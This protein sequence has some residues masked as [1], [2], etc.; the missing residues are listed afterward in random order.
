[1]KDFDVIGTSV[2]VDRVARVVTSESK[3]YH[4]HDDNTC[5]TE[6]PPIMEFPGNR[7]DNITENVFGRLTVIGYA[8][9][10][11]H[12]GAKWVVKCTCGNYQIITGKLLRKNNYI[13]CKDCDT[14]HLHKTG[15]KL[16][17]CIKNTFDKVVIELTNLN[18]DVSDSYV[19]NKIVN[20]L[21]RNG[22]TTEST[23]KTTKDVDSKDF[24][25]INA[26]VTA[27]VKY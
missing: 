18:P 6:I 22:I 1:M 21:N 16:N 7:I 27:R 2:P 5:S 26:I 25:N 13:V 10:S 8:G 11:R 4:I 14:L 12:S 24:K 19:T 9:S 3:D 23:G 15:N 20:I 17:D